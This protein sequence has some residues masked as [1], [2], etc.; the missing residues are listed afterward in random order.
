[1][2]TPLCEG[3][4]LLERGRA[5]VE[6]ALPLAARAAIHNLDS[7]GFTVDC[8]EEPMLVNTEDFE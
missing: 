3:G 6:I 4:E 2:D 5:K 8:N 1:M 7:H